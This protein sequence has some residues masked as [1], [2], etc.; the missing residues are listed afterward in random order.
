[1]LTMAQCPDQEHAFKYIG[2]PLSSAQIHSV[3]PGCS[4]ALKQGQ[5]PC[6]HICTS[7]FCFSWIYEAQNNR[8]YFSGKVCWRLISTNRNSLIW[9]LLKEQVWKEHRETFPSHG[10]YWMPNFGWMSLSLKN[11]NTS[12]L[13]AILPH[14]VH[15]IILYIII[16]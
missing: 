2:S 16:Y 7:D 12:H 9:G 11:V 1:M 10:V 13:F 5:V 14:S 4:S 3:K 15:R 6:S 8:S